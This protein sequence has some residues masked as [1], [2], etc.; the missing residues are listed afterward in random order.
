MSLLV[1]IFG[2]MLLTVLLYALARKFTLSN[3][4]S[5]V[6]A[7]AVPSVAYI[8]YAVSEW[9]G[10]DVITMHVVAYPTVAVMLYLLYGE[11]TGANG[12]GGIHWV[13]QI[14]IGFFV[15][16]TVLYG[17]F[18]YVAKQGIPPAF[19]AWLLPNTAG[20]NVHTG[21]AGVVAHG[22]DA[23][24]SIAH[25]RNMEEKLARL[26]WRV[27]VEGL[28]SL[29]VGQESAVTVSLT[30][31]RGDFVGDVRITLVLER[32]GQESGQRVV[33]VADPSVARYHGLARL[34]GQGVWLAVLGLEK[35]E[36]AVTLERVVGGE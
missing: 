35:G 31:T 23:A 16:I 7:A 11:K 18:V 19:A 25:H 8:L 6:L 29:K 22:D 15:L 33:F 30:G 12:G 14:I 1:T 17:G 3:Y 24:K 34:P 4:W 13:P 32:P 26:G 21:F 28:D 10:L 27:V 36:E 20:K 9:P 2:G 5:S